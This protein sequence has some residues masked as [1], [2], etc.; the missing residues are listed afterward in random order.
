[1]NCE[2]IYIITELAINLLWS[3]GANKVT[4]KIACS[5]WQVSLHEDCVLFTND[6]VFSILAQMCI[7]HL[8]FL[9]VMHPI[10]R[11]I[12]LVSLRKMVHS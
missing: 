2:I 6:Q 7:S 11:F 5:F 4:L 8:L 9:M 3:K 12:S 1:M 10:S